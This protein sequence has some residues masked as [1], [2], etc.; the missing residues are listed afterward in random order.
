MKDYVDETQECLL[1]KAYE[2]ELKGPLLKLLDIY[3]ESEK[4]LEMASE[5]K[6]LDEKSAQMALSL[7]LRARKCLKMVKEVKD[8]ALAPQKQYAEE[9]AKNTKPVI[10]EL[11]DIE[12]EMDIRLEHWALFNG[13][14]SLEAEEGSFNFRDTWEFEVVN[15]ERVPLKYSMVD[16]E[17]VKQ[18]V[19]DG[20]REIPGLRIYQD[21]KGVMRLNNGK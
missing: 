18:A 8:E 5:L 6:V 14:N 3:K 19:K 17:A 7:A 20:V 21:K 13:C 10:G 11:E 16:V 12:N 1:G 4:L 15:F 9:V 2:I